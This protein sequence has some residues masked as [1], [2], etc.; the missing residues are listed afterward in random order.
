MKKKK[1]YT[2]KGPLQSSITFK[3]NF[4]GYALVNKQKCIL[5]IFAVMQIL[6]RNK[7]DILSLFWEYN[8]KKGYKLKVL[9][10]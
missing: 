6:C 2:Y 7:D 8:I 4:Y 5:M 1:Y 9:Q 10:S 3:L